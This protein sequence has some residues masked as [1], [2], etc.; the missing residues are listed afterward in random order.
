MHNFE[1]NMFFGQYGKFSPSRWSHATNVLLKLWFLRANIG[2]V[3]AGGWHL[4]ETVIFLSFSLA[5]L[6]VLEVGSE[7]QIF[8]RFTFRI[9]R[10]LENF[11]I[12]F[13]KGKQD[14]I[15][16]CYVPFPPFLYLKAKT[17]PVVHETWICAEFYRDR[18]YLEWTGLVQ[19]KKMN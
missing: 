16:C 11:P 6:Q 5:S 9:S 8:Y 17:R 19:A 3:W 15:H 12:F 7:L 14:V 2:W 1:Q 18:R 10:Y 13:T 4:A